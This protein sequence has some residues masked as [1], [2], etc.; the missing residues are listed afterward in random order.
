MYDL[1][2]GKLYY[3]QG[4]GTFAA[5]S[6][7][8][9]PV[10]IGDFAR[11]IKKGYVGVP[12]YCTPVE[13]IQ[14]TGTQYIDTGFKTTANTRVLIDFKMDTYITQ[15]RFFGSYSTNGI[16]YCF[17]INGNQQ[18]GY[19]YQD[20]SGNWVNT[21]KAVTNNRIQVDFNGYAK[22]LSISGGVSYSSSLS[23]GA[24]KGS[25][26]NLFLFTNSEANGTASQKSKI[27]LY[28]CKIYDGE[29]LV[30]DYIPVLT[31]TNIACLY[32]NV[33]QELYLN[34]GTGSFGYG[35]ATGDD[36]I[37]LGMTARRIIRGYVGVNSLIYTPVEY[38][39]SSGTQYVDT[40]VKPT[41]TTKV[42]IK[43]SAFPP[44]TT[45][46][47]VFGSRTAGGSSDEYSFFRT[48]TGLYRSDFAGDRV[49]FD[50]GTNL[51]NETVITKDG[52][53]SAHY[54]NTVLITDGE[55]ELLTFLK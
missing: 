3:N 7:T 31:N 51:T 21:G 42:E 38:I 52:S 26:T 4:T 45:W 39:E 19:A 24:T 25:D 32:D 36:P 5:G 35:S 15:D 30:R 50:S 23:G 46:G 34:K 29:T 22:T 40:G 43:I 8:G 6:A 2:E 10:Y 41:N 20:D 1:V 14:S 28:S 55:P 54:E 44:N 47:C 9:D 33:T 37:D 48:D 27:R 18:Y 53:L 11:K 13:Y 17:Y 49:T 16:F 12:G